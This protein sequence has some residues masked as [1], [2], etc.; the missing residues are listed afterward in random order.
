MT[1]LFLDDDLNR[2]KAISPLFIKNC[3]EPIH[4]ETAKQAIEMLEDRAFDAIFLDHDL[5]GQIMVKS[6]EGTGFEV[7]QWIADNLT[8]KMPQVYIH[9]LNPVGGDN[10]QRVL[11]NA[12]RVPFGELLNRLKR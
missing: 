4:V 1:A 8:H 3:I 6:G 12:I 11:S 9:T 7:A 2:W 10:I 5:C